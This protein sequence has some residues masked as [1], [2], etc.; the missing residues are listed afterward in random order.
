[1]ALHL[2]MSLLSLKASYLPAGYCGDK[3]DFGPSFGYGLAQFGLL[4]FT[5]IA[6][7]VAAAF[8]GNVASRSDGK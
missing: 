8:H 5:I 1:M 4:F 6:L 3:S 7:C 2:L